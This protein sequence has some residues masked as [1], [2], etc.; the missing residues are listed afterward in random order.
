MAGRL[1]TVT[2]Y[3][4]NV[5]KSV[6]YAMVDTVTEP[7]ENISDFV[8][9]N[10][11]LFKT[12]YSAAK[13]YKKTMIAIDRSIKK[14]KIYDAASTGMRALKEDLRSGRFYNKERDTQMQLSSLGD[15][16]A[17]FSDF[18]SD[19]NFDMDDDDED[20]SDSGVTDGDKA[21]V[22]ATVKS[23]V[24]VGNVIEATSRAQSKIIARSAENI[25]AV[26]MQSTKLLFGQTEK[27]YKGVIDGFTGVSSGI[28][29]VTSIMNGPMITYMNESTKFYGDVST[30]LGEI[31]ALLKETTEM[32][33]NLYKEKDREYKTSAYDDVMSG[34]TPDL[35][36]Y[37]KRIYKN[38]K[39]LD[40]T[41]GMLFGDGDENL[42]KAFVGSPLKFIPNMISKL[43]IPTALSKSLELFDQTIGGLFSTFITRMNTWANSDS[44][45]GINFKGILGSILGIKIDKKTSMDPGKYN[46]GP[47][48]FDGETKKAIVDVIPTYLARI[49]SAVSGMPERVFDGR[50]GTFKNVSEIH[51]EYMN[52][53]KRAASDTMSSLDEYFDEWAR[54]RAA[55]SQGSNADKN[56]VYRDLKKR[57]KNV[58]KKVYNDGGDF[59]PYAGYGPR[60][61]RLLEDKKYTGGDMFDIED[62]TDLMRYLTDPAYN[63][64]AVQAMHDMYKISDNYV[65]AVQRNTR[66][67]EGYEGSMANPFRILFDG[68]L[69]TI[70]KHGRIK[71]FRADDDANKKKEYRKNDRFKTST[72]YLKDILAEIRWIRMKGTGGG[73]GGW[74]SPIN[75]GGGPSNRFIAGPNGQMIDTSRMTFEDFYKSNFGPDTYEDEYVSESDIDFSR[76][77][78][79]QQEEKKEK[80]DAE[81]YGLTKQNLKDLQAA[82]TI[83]EKWNVMKNKVNE[84]LKTPA[85]WAVDVVSKADK[86]IFDVMFGTEDGETF[87]DKYGLEYRGLLE[88]MVAKAGQIFEDFKD[89]MKEGWKAFDNWFSKTKVGGWIKEKGGAFAKEV[90]GALKEKFKFGKERFKEGVNDTFV[91]LLDRFTDGGF[92]EWRDERARLKE[93]FEERRRQAEYEDT[94]DEAMES[95]SGYGRYDIPHS[96]GGRQVTRTGPM[97]VSK[98]E[99]VI[100]NP[101]RRRRSSN[102]RNERKLSRAISRGSRLRIPGRSG[103]IDDRQAIEED[104]GYMAGTI[105]VSESEVNKQIQEVAQDPNKEKD[106]VES[107]IKKVMREVGGNGADVAADA[108]IGSGVSLITGLFGGPLLGAA[109]GAG[110]GLIKHSETV[111]KALFGEMGEDGNY[112]EGLIPKK[113]IDKFNSIFTKDRKKSMI[114]YGIA[115]TLISLVTPLGLVGGALAGATAGYVKHT[116]WFQDLMF[117]NE[118]KGKTGLMS[119]ETK[120]KLSKAFPKMGLGAGIGALFGPFG[121]VGN[122]MLGGAMGYVAST[123]KF[124][125]MLFGKEGEDGKKH[126]GILGAFKD[127]FINPIVK[128]GTEVAKN[129][130]EWGKKKI[131]SPLQTFAEAGGNFIKNTFQSLTWRVGDAINGVFERHVGMPIH[132]FLREKIFK[133]AAGLGKIMLKAGAGV[134][135][136]TVGLPFTMLGGLANTMK[137]SQIMRGSF[138]T[139]DAKERLAYR[140]KHKIRFAVGRG[141]DQTLMFDKQLANMTEDELADL[142]QNLGNFINARG[143]NNIAYRKAVRKAGSNISSYLDKNSAWNK[144]NEAGIKNAYKLKKKLLNALQDGKSNEELIKIAARHGVSAEDFAKM[145]GD[146]DLS[147]MANLRNNAMQEAGLDADTIDKLEK[148]TG[149]SLSSRNNVALRRMLQLSRVEYKSRHA[150]NKALEPEEQKENEE[151][152]LEERT[153]KM[154]DNVDA[155]KNILIEVNNSING[156]GHALDENGNPI[157][158]SEEE[159]QEKTGSDNGEN[160]EDEVTETVQDIKDAIIQVN[161]SLNGCGRVLDKNGNEVSF[162]EANRMMRDPKNTE[163]SEGNGNRKSSIGNYEGT[164][165]D[166]IDGDDKESFE[167][168][169]AAKENMSFREKIANGFHS[170]SE[171]LGGLFGNKDKEDKKEGGLLS[172]IFGGMKKGGGFI[173]NAISSLLGAVGGSKLGLVAAAIGGVASL[174]LLGHISEAFKNHILPVLEKSPLFQKIAALAG[175]LWDKVKDGSLFKIL[176]SKFAQGLSFALKNVAAPLTAAIISSFPDII[177]GIVSGTVMGVKQLFKPEERVN[178]NFS[179]KYKA[180]FKGMA[181]GKDEDF[182]SKDFSGGNSSSVNINEYSIGSGSGSSDPNSLGTY[183]V[184]TKYDQGTT[185]LDN[186]STMDVD[187]LGNV[188]ARD[189]KGNVLGVYNQETG[190]LVQTNAVVGSNPF[191][192]GTGNLFKQALVGGPTAKFVG[193]LAGKMAGSKFL[194]PES[195]AKSV[196]HV[197]FNPIGSGAMAMGKGTA[198]IA[199]DV[200]SG[201]F[202]AGNTVRNLALE[203]SRGFIGLGDDAAGALL[204]LNDKM[205]G[206]ATKNAF[207][208]PIA[209]AERAIANNE[210]VIGATF[211]FAE[212]I[213][214]IGKTLANSKFASTILGFL[215]KAFGPLSNIEGVN[216]LIIK[217]MD[218]IGK[219][220][221]TTAAGKIAQGAAQKIVGAIAKFSPAAIFFWVQKFIEG[222]VEK[223][224]TVLGIAKNASIDLTVGARL[225]IG[226]IHAVNENLLFGFI[227]TK[228]LVE[229]VI[230]LCGDLIGVTKEEFEAAQQK[231]D[232]LLTQASIDAG[233]QV[234]LPEYNNQEG[235]L[236]GAWASI[237]RFVKGEEKV[238][239]KDYGGAATVG[240][241]YSAAGNHRN[242]GPINAGKVANLRNRGKGRGGQQGG[243]FAS[244]RYG[245]ST[246]GKAG[247]APV[248]AASILGGNI[249]E[250]ANFAQRT[251]HVAADGSTDI[252]YFR[253]YFSAKGIPNA[254]TTSKGAVSSALNRG[255]SAVLLGRDP[256]G[257][258]DSAY[259]NNSHF[260]TARGNRDGSVTVNDPALG[261]RKMSKSKVLKNMKASVLT[262][263]GR[264]GGFGSDENRTGGGGTDS[265]TK[266]YRGV[267]YATV[268]STKYGNF[269]G[270]DKT[271]NNINTII[272]TARAEIGTTEGYNNDNKYGAEYGWNNVAWCVIFVW[273]VFKHAGASKLFMNG[274][275][276]ASCWELYNYFAANNQVVSTIKRGDIVFLNFHGGTDLSHVEIATEDADYNAK[277]VKCIGGNTSPGSSGSQSNGDGVYE[278]TRKI[279]NIVKV[280]RPAYEGAT[281]DD[282]IPSGTYYNYS[283]G[284]ATQDPSEMTLFEK[285][286]ALGKLALKTLFGEGLYNAVFGSDKTE[287]TGSSGGSYGSYGAANV[288]SDGQLIGKDAAERTWRYLRSKGYSKESIAGIMGSLYHESGMR[289]NN[290]Q[291]DYE[292]RLGYNDDSYT[293]AVN[294]GSYGA[295]RFANDSAGYGLAQWTYNTR[296][297]DLY[298]RTVAAGIPIDSEK[299]QLDQLDR[300]IESYGLA[301]QMRNHNNVY[302]ATKQFVDVF[303]KPD[304]SY[305]NSSYNTRAATA[306]AYY[307]AFKDLP[308][309][310][311]S[312]VKSESDLTEN[313]NNIAS[314]VGNAAGNINEMYQRKLA[315]NGNGVGTVQNV[316]YRTGRPTVQQIQEARGSGRDD[317]GNFI[318]NASNVD[319]GQFLKIIIDA[320]LSIADNTEALSKILDILSNNFDI[321]VDSEDVKK[322]AKSSR[323]KARQALNNLLRDNNNNESVTNIMQ[324]KDTAYLVNVMTQIARE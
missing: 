98:G 207:L 294:S 298:D 173:G 249:P 310:T 77:Y 176:A 181:T 74:G 178:T 175:G 45:D 274:G 33:R 196:L 55:D 138:S 305:A 80:T 250:A 137:T 195:I 212:K 84:L 116:D 28:N 6:A 293:E 19:F 286:A 96:A 47:I 262:G 225:I 224:E 306:Q 83:T 150:E 128:A 78:Q 197:P 200:V 5:G 85:K 68:S 180:A 245:N 13:N 320:L 108:L 321:N 199:S 230:N 242:S 29:M 148:L 203:G 35:T 161:N 107:A 186:G 132:E 7:T 167:A 109:A 233:R 296:K 110:F 135:K 240:V 210:K 117:G 282:A 115:G 130:L 39:N 143:S 146:T 234:G 266:A 177:K 217:V 198:K 174:S 215:G 184:T 205:A 269:I 16:F 236:K 75:N 315:L 275:K 54:K 9:T 295:D 256:G 300:E 22:N 67:L 309:Y 283:T 170:I 100:P 254:T 103:T 10:Q 307:D 23:S 280:C 119:R 64:K 169:Q 50:S 259:S 232:E 312:E 88:F 276:T 237:K 40:P 238:T 168:R 81:R 279:A 118:A 209:A 216:K 171:K 204:K 228:L 185:T 125:E 264:G 304:M 267:D 165:G 12:I 24:A 261:L 160:N 26:N 214:N 324:T 52:M 158:E 289:S 38:I 31:S 316:Q 25:A 27:L 308:D 49:E 76:G 89:K 112:K 270:T 94:L 162:T 153:G 182:I 154:Y 202:N 258:I 156:K 166:D 142:S 208:K 247:C 32:Q 322:A 104:D 299:G 106:K 263:R 97:I 139:A 11:E 51:R 201:T 141:G 60:G 323:E 120:E 244:M 8:E 48:P 172:K 34:N 53:E 318:S 124:K 127:G 192:H 211:N 46:R 246:I 183:N 303:E 287:T 147:E 79:R 291:N 194:S 111:Q 105:P 92:S 129:L 15:D 278:K 37:A 313:K 86:R 114:D 164:N 179:A 123:D 131:I 290:L 43:I 223:T 281:F 99:I 220:T 253:D 20:S 159:T 42:F 239:Y 58:G 252:G 251:G 222:A 73:H 59:R 231:T 187:M 140:D 273:W 56:R 126:G 144:G 82:Q 72:D 206:A 288:T 122:V 314:V 90:G 157:N 213:S 65:N 155:I 93:E 226:L 70:D 17:D 95:Y 227:P 235:L 277:T 265:I 87:K 260:I 136:M 14:S 311:E 149:M 163:D 66:E 1:P 271:N 4:K 133:R 18:E 61:E 21:V 229:L 188:T 63:K 134:A 319:Y 41:G 151:K 57:W 69:A 101:N 302:D 44:L 2:E 248:A 317:E 191:L 30:K 268:N 152:M 62:W 3:I 255:S 241:Q 301:Y 91:P 297:K 219:K 221:A 190:E 257:G 193:K 189:K 102:A 36:N 121:L 145:M 272:K 285:F 284:E 218:G 113:T 71:G 243:A 292:G